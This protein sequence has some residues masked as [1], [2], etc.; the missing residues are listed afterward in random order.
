MKSQTSVVVAALVGILTVFG[1]SGCSEYE[2]LRKGVDE[3]SHP[4]NGPAPLSDQQEIK[5]IDSMRSKGSFEAARDRLTNTA[6]AIAEQISAA[7]PGQ[8]WKFGDGEYATDA[9]KDGSLCDKLDPGIVRRPKAKPVDF[10]SPFTADGFKTAVDIVRH[11][12]TKYGATVQSSLFNESAKRD[13]DVQGNGYEFRILQIKTAGLD[14]TGDCRLLQ[15]VI[16]LPP[17][18]LP[19]EPP[20]VPTTTT[21]P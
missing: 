6:Q 16:D 11:A 20:I 9:Y 17:G 10:G 13:Y 2:K 12:A 21:S 5:L 15:K 8:S 7:I 18:Q 3:L 4:D 1:V 14:I 19:P